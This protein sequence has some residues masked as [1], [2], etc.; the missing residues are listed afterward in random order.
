MACVY[1]LRRPQVHRVVKDK[2]QFQLAKATMR[3]HFPVR[4]VVLSACP[5][6]LSCS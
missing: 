4:P 6:R 1:R 3:K 5:P 2:V